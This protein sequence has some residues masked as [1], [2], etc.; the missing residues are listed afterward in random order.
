MYDKLVPS[1]LVLLCAALFAVADTSAPTVV[2][3]SSTDIDFDG[4]L[5]EDDTYYHPG[6][7]EMFEWVDPDI[8]TGLENGPNGGSGWV[9]DQTNLIAGEVTDTTG[10]DISA[11]QPTP[12]YTE[13]GYYFEWAKVCDITGC[14]WQLSFYDPDDDFIEWQR[15][16][17][18]SPLAAALDAR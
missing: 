8:G 7:D 15:L 18:L 1:L 3:L 16:D 5:D 13:T 6:N 2:P 4:T 10:V 14:W 17:P 11:P 12:G 9:L